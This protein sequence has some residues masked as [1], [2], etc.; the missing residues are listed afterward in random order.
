MEIL[1]K[2]TKQSLN[3]IPYAKFEIKQLQKWLAELKDGEEIIISVSTKRSSNQN[4]MFHKWCALVGDYM[5]ENPET[6]KMWL[7]CK[8]LGCVE[9]EIEG[10]IYQIPPETSKLNKKQMSDFMQQVYIFATAEME[11]KLPSNEELF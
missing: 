8:F 4:A 9:E 11:I 1:L 5:G 7:K 3:E 10:V 6:V 2:G